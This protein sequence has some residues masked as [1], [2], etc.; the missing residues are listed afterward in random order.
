MSR[1]VSVTTVVP[2]YNGL[3]FLPDAVNSLLA[4]T[5]QGR[6]L[7]IDDGSTDGSGEYLDRLSDSRVTVVHQPNVGLATTLNHAYMDLVD[8]EFVARL[9]QD[10]VASPN[11]LATQLDIL[12][13][14]R[15]AAAVFTSVAKIGANGQRLN[16]H[17]SADG[18]TVTYEPSA[19]MCPL[20]ST[21][22]ARTDA[23][24]SA[25]G[26]RGELY[27]SDD[28]DLA[29]R[30]AEKNL[31]LLLHEPLVSYRVHR[32]NATWQTWRSGEF[33]TRYAWA[34]H[35]LRVAG[36]PEIPLETWK[37]GSASGLGELRYRMGAIGRLCF[38]RAGMGMGEGR[39]LAA[40][41]WM[42]PAMLLAPRFAWQG[43]RR[44]TRP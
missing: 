22:M 42:G 23:L 18:R 41:C 36:L 37:A 40:A 32:G 10:D 38:R 3:P 7:L 16:V 1:D 8:T 33:T 13:A 19:I 34:M 15:D 28:Y 30:L 9:D 12:L 4:Q 25:G 39:R 11:R 29:L 43:L 44:A 27:P 17:P 26:H 6:I 14:R 35:R 24:V 21:M 20:P 5:L 2:I 31:V